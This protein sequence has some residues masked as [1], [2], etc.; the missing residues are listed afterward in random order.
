M[1]TTLGM[2][3]ES[4]KPLEP[5]HSCPQGIALAEEGRAEEAAQCFE[6][7]LRHRP[8]DAAAWN[9]AGVVLFS[10]G[11]NGDAVA[12]LERARELIADDPEICRNLVR[13]YLAAGQ[14]ERT[15]QCLADLEQSGRL[16]D[17]WIEETARSIWTGG[18]PAGAMESVLLG[19]Q[20]FP[21][22]GIL[23][24]LAET[25]RNSRP[26][27]AFF[28]GGDGPTFLRQ[29]EA[30]VRLRFP[31]RIFEGNTI[32]EVH[33]LMNHSDISWFEWCT[34][35]AEIGSRHAARCKKIIRLHRYEAYLD[36]PKRVNWDSVDVLITV[37]NRFVREAL[38]EQQP[39]LASRIRMET[40]P[41]GVDLDRIRFQ[42][43]KRGKRL[44]FI[45][46]TRMVKNPMLLLQCMDELHHCDSDYH[47]HI[48]GK[49]QDKSLDQY[50]R[51]MVRSLGLGNVVHFDGW[52]EDIPAWLAD[53]HYI[54]CTSVI[55]SQGMGI[56]EAMAAG[57]K[58]VIH[59]FPGAQDT[60]GSEWLFRTP[61]EFRNRI[62][63]TD[64]FPQQYRAFV[65]RKYSLVRQLDR[66]G[67]VL[68]ELE[69]RIRRDSTRE[70]GG[71]V[72]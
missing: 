38:L 67:G 51:H 30:F 58:P 25:I 19:I 71:S 39:N 65:E 70:Y 13:A 37:G 15:K 56:L 42:R 31:V 8:D 34:E 69:S 23:L 35:L 55:E 7:Y 45:G 21:D 32:P 57:L 24:R 41:N 16:E 53:K 12:C 20:F 33:Q 54:V 9:D 48:A 63:S 27:V 60:F 64:Y 68:T 52:Q 18:N 26:G 10:L 6:D 40:I 5:A 50:L 2:G 22:S 3:I 46:D 14:Y 72:R 11:R 62:E 66:V 47:L 17:V 59:D 36:W 43:R 4:E 61:R 29:I 1:S 44:A 49:I 28:C